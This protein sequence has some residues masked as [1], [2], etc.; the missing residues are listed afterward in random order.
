M[1]FGPDWNEK[2]N[3]RRGAEGISGAKKTP[4]GHE[5]SGVDRDELSSS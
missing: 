4:F 5:A 2:R 1:G 3:V